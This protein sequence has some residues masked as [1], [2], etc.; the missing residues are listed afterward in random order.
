LLNWTWLHHILL[1]MHL[2]T[3][4]CFNQITKGTKRGFPVCV[5][6]DRIVMSDLTQKDLPFFFRTRKNS[7]CEIVMTFNYIWSDQEWFQIKCSKRRLSIIWSKIFET[8]V[9][10]YLIKNDWNDVFP[11]FDLKFSKRLFSIIWSK[12]IK[13]T[14]FNYLI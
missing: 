6:L 14:V 4:C 10:N 5:E 9:A 7:S 1:R 11:L 8:T 13:T 3:N 2:L 12:M